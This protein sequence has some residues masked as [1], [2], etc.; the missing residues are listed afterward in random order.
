MASVTFTGFPPAGKTIVAGGMSCRHMILLLT[1][2]GLLRKA[3]S[4]A[5]RPPV[6]DSSSGG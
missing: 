1:D 6:A 5:V 2:A 4:A 3:I